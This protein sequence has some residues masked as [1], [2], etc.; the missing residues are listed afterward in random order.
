MKKRYFI[1]ALFA[2]LILA[3]FLYL[4]L[5]EEPERTS[6]QIE[7]VPLNQEKTAKV[8]SVVD[9]S[10][11]I[12]DMPSNGIISLRFY[13]FEGNERIWHDGFLIGKNGIVK[14]GVPDIYVFMHAKYID[15]L[16]ERDLCEVMNEAKA[17]EDMAIETTRNKGILLAKYSGM[18]EHKECFGF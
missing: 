8:V 3:G 11:F 6:V 15:R 1:V 7:V 14:D 12:S 5:G 18:L 2:A 10:E 9:E 16:Y 4:Y 17:N 13:S